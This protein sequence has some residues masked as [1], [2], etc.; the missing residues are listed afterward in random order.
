MRKFARL[1]AIAGVLALTTLV[2]APG[3]FAAVSGSATPNTGLSDLQTIHVQASGLPAVVQPIAVLECVRGATSSA[4][5]EGSTNDPSVNS[6][7]SGTYNNPNY[8]VFVLPDAVFPTVSIQ[9]DGSGQ[10]ECD[11]Y[12]GTDFNDFSQPHTFVP[13]EFST[14]GQGVP[15]VPYAALLPVGA[16]LVIA[17]GF[18]L[19]R[20]RNGSTPV[21]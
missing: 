1:A 7:A 12:I 19:H 18:V 13:I 6:T 11:L 17:A 4:Q 3:A 20:R 10:H 15:E 14:P 21:A 9:C 5:C 2:L 16:L 8:T